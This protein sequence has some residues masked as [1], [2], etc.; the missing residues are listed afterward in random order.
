MYLID[1][2]VA[3]E[4]RKRG[5]ANRGVIRFFEKV[6]ADVIS[7]HLWRGNPETKSLDHA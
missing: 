4:A 7:T 5:D 3:S 6:Q 1:T 2:N